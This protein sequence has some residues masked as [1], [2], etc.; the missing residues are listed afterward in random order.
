MNENVAKIA[1]LK[2]GAKPSCVSMAFDKVIAP[3]LGKVSTTSTVPIKA[4]T[5]KM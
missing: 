5:T 1:R 2:L 3:A 4:V